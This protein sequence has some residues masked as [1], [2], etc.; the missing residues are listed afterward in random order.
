MHVTYIQ[1][2]WIND[3]LEVTEV[4]V[5]ATGFEFTTP[6]FVNEHSTN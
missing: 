6:K 3:C 2:I 5:R 1:D 4:E